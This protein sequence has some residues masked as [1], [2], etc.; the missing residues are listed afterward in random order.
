LPDTADPLPRMLHA[1]AFEPYIRYIR[2]PHFRNLRDELRIEFDYPVTALVGPNG[3]NKTAILRAL[4]G[5]PDYYNVGQYWFSTN[6]D[7]ISPDERHRF[8]H[9]YLAQTEGKVVEVIKTRI[10]RR[11][12]REN[13]SLDP[14]YFEPSRPL[15]QDG[16]ERLPPLPDGVKST[17]DRTA[18][19]WKAIRKDVV[20]LDFR[21]QLPAFDKYFYQ[22]PYN[23]RVRTL[24]DKKRFIRRRS[25]H[26][27]DT[28]DRE[29]S[30]HRYYNR[31]RVIKPTLHLDSDQVSAI[32]QILG[33]Q[34]DSV[35]ILEHRYFDFDGY[36]VRLQAPQR[37]YSEA[38]AGSGEFAAAMLV[39]AVTTA[40]AHSLILLD[41]PEVSL[42]PG[43]QRRLLSFIRDQAR[44]QSHQFVISTHSPE[45]IRDLPGIAI[46]LFQQDPRDGRIELLS[47]ATEP[48]DA[49]FRLGVPT[50][51]SYPIYVED[52]LAAAIVRR[53][54]RPLGEGIYQQVR[55]TSVPG[56][57]SSIKNLIPSFAA[58]N[59]K[60][61]IF[62]DGD[63]RED[64]PEGSRIVPDSE[65]DDTV[66]RV[67][68]TPP[69]LLRHG[70]NDPNLEAERLRQLRNLLDWMPK[71]VSYLPGNDPESMLLTLLGIGTEFTSATA[72]QEWERRAREAMGRQSYEPVTSADII[73]EQ[74]R[75]LA[76]LA[77][78][79]TDLDEI[80]LRVMEFIEDDS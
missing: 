19:R 51:S 25:I 44:L 17:D 39:Y 29:R 55:I 73:G 64:M 52:G 76:S 62:L 65:L 43:G 53:A 31:E 72:K 23:A 57:A 49:F 46:K 69:R 18:T 27:A 50:R 8:I 21:S 30:R 22:I 4:Q 75:A 61:L 42:H 16:M 14:D 36:S 74:E 5:C 33:R 70:G 2:F 66:R 37:W 77:T 32:S 59:Q 28:F 38:F 24:T 11:S 6:L 60:C 35:S 58:L 54:I 63:Q 12:R 67:L 34:Y 9:G 40:K 45:M 41:E 80:R 1:G 3:T 10:A 78:E 47:Q 48:T 15:V 26:L 79:D 20:Y 56:G 13:Q 68:G 7:P 71:H